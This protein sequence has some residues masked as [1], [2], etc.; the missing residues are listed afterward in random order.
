MFG[1]GSLHNDKFFKKM[2]EASLHHFVDGFKKHGIHKMSQLKS[3]SIQQIDEVAE[4][5]KMPRGAVDRLLGILKKSRGGSST[6]PAAKPAAKKKVASVSKPK[7][8]NNP[9]EAVPVPTSESK[10]EGKA[11]DSQYYHFSSTPKEHARQFDAVKVEDPDSAKWQ[12]KEGASSWNPGNTVEDRDFSPQARAIMKENLQQFSFGNGIS[13]KKV[14]STSGDFTIIVNRGKVKTIF[15]MSFECE[16]EGTA[17]EDKITGTL[18]CTDIMPDED[19]DDWYIECKTKKKTTQAREMK[20]YV[21][22]EVARLKEEVVDLT[23]AI[24]RSKVVI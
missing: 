7:P 12:V 17:G 19:I 11:T 24:L 21:Q 3:K 8:V 20:Q 5:I 4:Q 1:S 15:D 16:W 13:V 2:G 23:V 22:N 14:K 6:K 10:V 18:K 9:E